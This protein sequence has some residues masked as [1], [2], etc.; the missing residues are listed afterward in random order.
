MNVYLVVR[1]NGFEDSE[2]LYAALSHKLAWDHAYER[3]ARAENFEKFL[4]LNDHEI[5][6]TYT[7]G[8]HNHRSYALSWLIVSRELHGSPLDAL[9]DAAE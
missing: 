8:P 3:A 4:N 5:S 7:F 6:A 2:I 9:A 1:G